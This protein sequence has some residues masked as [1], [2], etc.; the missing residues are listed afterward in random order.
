MK[1]ISSQIESALKNNC[2]MKGDRVTIPVVFLR[3]EEMLV[4]KRSEYSYDLSLK[5]NQ[6]NCVGYTGNK[7]QES[8]VKD[9]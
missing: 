8:H 1:V 9:I 2:S 5:E 7:R 3:K 6:R 4:M